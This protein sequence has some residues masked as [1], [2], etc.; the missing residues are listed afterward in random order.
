MLKIVYDIILKFISSDGTNVDENSTSWG[1]YRDGVVRS[2]SGSIIKKAGEYTKLKTG[3]TE[4]TMRKNIYDIA[5]N[6]AEITNEVLENAR[7][8]RVERGGAAH[9][10]SS[11]FA[12][13]MHKLPLNYE[14]CDGFR[15]AL[16]LK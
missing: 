2:N 16:F 7:T 4:Y 15:I 13:A 11:F 3:E 12:S 6:V 1:N 9:Y 14:I 8:A 5:G 10:Y